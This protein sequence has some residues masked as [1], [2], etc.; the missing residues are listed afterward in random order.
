MKLADELKTAKNVPTTKKTDGNAWNA[1][2][3]EME[4]QGKAYAP[5]WLDARIVETAKSIAKRLR[6]RYETV[7]DAVLTDADNYK[8]FAD[9]MAKMAKSE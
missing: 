1:K 5:I 2:K 3:A 9:E 4:Q 8:T 6:V 7:L